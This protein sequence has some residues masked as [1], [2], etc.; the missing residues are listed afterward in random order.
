MARRGI[1]EST[2]SA[3]HAGAHLLPHCGSTNVRLTAH[4]PLVVPGG[5]CSIR[6]G[7]EVRQQ[8][9]QKRKF[10]M[11]TLYYEY[12]THMYRVFGRLT[13]HLPLV[14]P[15]GACSIRVGDEVRQQTKTKKSLY[16]YTILRV[17]DTYVSSFWAAHS[18]FAAGGA[19]RRLLDPGGGRDAPTNKNEVF[20][21]IHYTTSI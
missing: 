19:G 8:Q 11:Y 4:L 2:F 1:G 9:Q 12:M 6:V 21:S 13:A 7:D 14:V 20:I 17:Y 16:I 3:L 5:A 15:G 18:A 10:Y